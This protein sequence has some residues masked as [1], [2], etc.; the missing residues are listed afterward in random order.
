MLAIHISGAVR[1]KQQHPVFKSEVYRPPREG[2]MQV[3]LQGKTVLITGGIRGIGRA[4][5]EATAKAGAHV[6]DTY[7]SNEATAHDFIESPRAQGLNVRGY[8]MDVR[9]S[10]QVDGARTNNCKISTIPDM[11][12]GPHPAVKA[13]TPNS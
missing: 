8:K 11:M 1:P 10:K 9:N 2:Q 13:S 4:M 3:S 12:S 5:T 7:L 6:V